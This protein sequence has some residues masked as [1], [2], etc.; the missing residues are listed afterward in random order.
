VSVV[1]I[2]ATIKLLRLYTCARCGATA[3]GT[4]ER[5]ELEAGGLEE[6]CDRI[7]SLGPR[8]SSMPVGWGSYYNSGATEF[9][10]GR[11]VS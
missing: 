6:L 11:C 10:C 1:T 5:G 4:T 8:P 3:A 2:H 9:R 7:R